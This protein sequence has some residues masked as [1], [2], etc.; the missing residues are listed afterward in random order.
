MNNAY[1]NRKEL[2]ESSKEIGRRLAEIRKSKHI[3]QTE[4]AKILGVTQSSL[5]QLE[6]GF[7]MWSVPSVIK[8]IK[9]Y[10]VPY[11]DVFGTWQGTETELPL[12]ADDD[13]TVPIAVL[14]MLAQTSDLEEIS[15]SVKAYIYVCVY[16][17]FRHLYEANPKNSS[18]I[19]SLD[20]DIADRITEKIFT[21]E[22]SRLNTFIRYSSRI[23]S[24]EIE[25]PIEYSQK[26]RELVGKCE[27]LMKAYIPEFDL[28]ELKP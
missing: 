15:M 18:V 17:M 19:F 13:I 5:S 20:P 7:R 21:E 24:K 25:L 27:N 9:Y 10:K 22:P 2:F 6:S 3:S 11:E 28:S 16:R 23:N 1:T 8:L 26:L 4:A 12:T 14:E